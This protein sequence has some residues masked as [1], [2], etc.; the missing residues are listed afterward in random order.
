MNNLR[1]LVMQSKLQKDQK[2]KYEK[3]IV[4]L[5]EIF[6]KI[7]QNNGLQIQINSEVTKLLNDTIN[8]FQELSQAT[9]NFNKSGC[10]GSSS[11]LKSLDLQFQFFYLDIFKSWSRASQFK[12]IDVP[13][14]P[15]TTKIPQFDEQVFQTQ[16]HSILEQSIPNTLLNLSILKIDSPSKESQQD[17]LQKNAQ[18][19]V[20]ISNERVR[21]AHELFYGINQPQN[22]QKALKIYLEEAQKQN[23]HAC[24]TLGKLYFEGKF[25]KQDISKSMEFYEKSELQQN[26]EA[27]YRLGIMHEKGLVQGKSIDEQMKI[28]YK[29]LIQAAQKQHLD[30]LTD[31]G[32]MYEKGYKSKATGNVIIPQ[33]LAQ[34]KSHYLEA[35]K[36]LYPRA[37]N[38]YGALLLNDSYNSEEEYQK[39]MQQAVYWF[40]QCRDLEYDKGIFNLGLCYE[41]GKGVPKDLA[42][43]QKLFEEAA[44]RGDVDAKLF[45]LYYLLQN[46]TIN[47][48]KQQQAQAYDYLQSIIIQQILLS[49]KLIIIQDTYMSMGQGYNRNWSQLQDIIRKLVNLIIQRLQTNQEIYFIQ[50]SEILLQIQK[51]LQNIIQKLQNQTLSQL[52]SS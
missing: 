13:P 10:C 52:S 38:N 5:H 24:N 30:A 3:Q 1:D 14:M 45:Y 25:V 47:N 42:K 28:C 31:L 32:Y 9:Q 33:D 41:K 12:S 48:D 35:I 21:E 7:A 22:I 20:D 4:Q 19:Q 23:V 34:A 51:L 8:K 36:Q 46:A 37:M 40:E 16:I 49:I 2:A 27:I 29:Y 18:K 17:Q 15:S 39:G 6:K 44:N 50:E 11:S 43:A 26:P